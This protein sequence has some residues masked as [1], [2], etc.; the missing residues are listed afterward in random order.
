MVSRVL[1][2][3]SSDGGDLRIID[4][5][6]DL[7]VK[8]PAGT[9]LHLGSSD[10]IRLASYAFVHGF[11]VS[12]FK[13]ADAYLVPLK[14]DKQREVSN[15]LLKVFNAHGSDEVEAALQDEYDGLYVVSV[16]LF[17]SKS[18]MP[19]TVSRRGFVN[20]VVRKEAEKLLK[21]AWRELRLT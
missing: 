17:S 18:R 8:T 1:L 4:F 15:H 21:S 9:E 3:P 13:M 11:E 20:T 16:E 12:S 14:A 19:I 7:P 5:G 10:L 2:S 6:A